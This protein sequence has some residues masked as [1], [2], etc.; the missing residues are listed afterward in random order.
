MRSIFSLS[1]ILTI[2]FSS[3]YIYQLA[4]AVCPIPLSYSIAPIDPRFGVSEALV[5]EAVEEA[6]QLWESATGRELFVA[7][8]PAD[9]IISF[10]YD[11]RQERVVAEASFRE[12]L[13]IASQSSE[14]VGAEYARLSAE[15]DTQTEQFESAVATHEA[16]LATYNAEVAEYNRSGGAP[17]EAFAE[18]K[19]R[20]A[21]LARAAA[22]LERTADELQVQVA[23]LN[24]LA[25]EGNELIEL[26]NS[27]VASYNQTFGESAEFTQ[28]D[29]QNN[30]ITIYKFA[31]RTELINVLAHE[32]GHALGIGHV[33][34]E[35]SIMYYL[36][37]E[38]PDPPA[39]S[40]TDIEAFV[41]VCGDA[42]GW[43]GWWQ[44]L[45]SLY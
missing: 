11:D 37:G 19:E 17:P 1:L 18:L 42:D 36:M 7:E 10:V 40:A 38:Q 6:E 33:E 32:F 39:V 26:Y 23:R 30:Q 21:S 22:D 45:R 43:A 31:D 15:Y 25:R 29:F 12:D 35:A 14:A 20:E 24:Q 44:R 41:S 8:E 3:A 4:A 2:V 34:G 16:N 5:T 9:L 27:Q 28:G 13:D